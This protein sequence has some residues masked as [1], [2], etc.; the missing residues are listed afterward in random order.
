M[1]CCHYLGVRAIFNIPNASS[2]C[3]ERTTEKVIDSGN[4][5]MEKLSVLAT[6]EVKM[7]CY[8][9]SPQSR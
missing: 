7:I 9:S 5:C 3:N 4:E 2:I 8:G 6:D 1:G